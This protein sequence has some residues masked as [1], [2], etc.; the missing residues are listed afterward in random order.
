VVGRQLRVELRRLD[1][2]RTFLGR[3]SA[4]DQA[5][6]VNVADVVRTLTEGRRRGAERDGRVAT[7]TLRIFTIANF[8]A[9]LEGCDHRP[10]STQDAAVRPDA[11]HASR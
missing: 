6:R 7:K 11:D 10:M 2:R 3:D 5:Y 1:R 8:M 9:V 4:T